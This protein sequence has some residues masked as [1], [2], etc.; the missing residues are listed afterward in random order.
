MQICV[1]VTEVYRGASAFRL[2]ISTSGSMLAGR[3]KRPRHASQPTREKR[4][5]RRSS[6]VF[7][8][9]VAAA[10]GPAKY[11][12]RS[13][14]PSS[15]ALR[16][17]GVSVLLARAGRVPPSEGRPACVSLFSLS[18]SRPRRQLSFS[19]LRSPSP[20]C[21]LSLPLPPT[22]SLALAFRDAPNGGAR[23]NAGRTT[24]LPRIAEVVSSKSR[25]L[26]ACLV[27]LSTPALGVQFSRDAVDVS[28]RVAR[29]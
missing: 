18:L 5:Y 10:Y 25:A 17:F 2:N 21:S 24:V 29:P 4:T 9:P 26:D 12:S 11:P 22:P 6:D 8:V 1:I 3:R 16:C 19:S 27:I 7:G 15:R 23:V 13:R 14:S 28:P 20:S